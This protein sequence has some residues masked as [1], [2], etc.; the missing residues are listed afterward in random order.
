MLGYPKCY[1]SRG[2]GPTWVIPPFHDSVKR[3]DAW[4]MMELKSG[5][6]AEVGGQSEASDAIMK[7]EFWNV[8]RENLP[9]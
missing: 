9:K 2:F 5:S 3:I 4:K 6:M 8:S 7:P 1:G